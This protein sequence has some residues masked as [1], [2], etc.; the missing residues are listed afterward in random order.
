MKLAKDL[1]SEKVSTVKP[2]DSIAD[3]GNQLLKEKRSAAVVLED[4]KIIGMVSKEGFVLG[5]RDLIG[6]RFDKT[7]IRNYMDRKVETIDEKSEIADVV[8][9]LLELPS[10]IERLPVTSD[11]KLVGIISKGDVVKLFA[12]QMEG[13]FTVRDLMEYKPCIVDDYS[14]LNDIIREIEICGDKR[15]YVRSGKEIV[16]I[17]A[18]LDLACVLFE[19]MNDENI[20]D[21]LTSMKA[22]DF[23]KEGLVQVGPDED[24]AKVAKIM[25][26]QNIGGILVVEKGTEG[27]ITKANIVK[28]YNLALKD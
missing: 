21:I 7:E 20:G 13:R 11:G 23:M 12:E 2:T 19:K 3:V 26:D 1:M 14:V 15:V 27:V 18:I 8:E 28:G 25:L 16:G 22:K 9:K 24:A 6:K 10:R 17:I 4:D 5:V